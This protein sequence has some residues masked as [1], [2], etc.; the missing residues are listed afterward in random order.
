MDTSTLFGKLT[1]HLRVD[2]GEA[3]LSDAPGIGF[4][5]MPVFAE[6]FSGVLN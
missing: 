4:E 2:D 5:D 3:R 1:A 6:L